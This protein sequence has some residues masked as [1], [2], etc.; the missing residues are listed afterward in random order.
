M[1]IPGGNSIGLFVVTVRAVGL[2]AVAA[3]LMD[4]D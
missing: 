4:R 3:A 2:T 1:H